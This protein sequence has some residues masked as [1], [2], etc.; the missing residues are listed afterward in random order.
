MGRYLPFPFM[1]IETEINNFLELVLESESESEEIEKLIQALDRLANLTHE[2][3]YQYDKTDYSDSLNFEYSTIRKKVEKRFP[4]LGYYNIALDISE[5]VGNSDIA[6]GDAIDDITDITLDLLGVKWR[7]DN[8]SPDDALWHLE[9]L[10]R[11]H[12]GRHLREL[13]LYLHDLY[14]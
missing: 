7:F 14:W 1:N 12:W 10:F 3:E 8:T 2:I 6:T 11:S 5:N 4:N 9:L 13:Q